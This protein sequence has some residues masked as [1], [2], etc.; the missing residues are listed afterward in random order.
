MGLIVYLPHR[1]REEGCE[2]DVHSRVQGTHTPGARCPA[3]CIHAIHDYTT[4]IPSSGSLLAVL[5][6]TL[7]PSLSGSYETAG[8]S[9]RHQRQRGRRQTPSPTQN[10]TML[11]LIR[12]VGKK[13]HHYSQPRWSASS[14]IRYRRSTSS[15]TRPRRSTSSHTRPRWSN[16]SHTRYRRSTSSHTRPRRST[17]SHTRP[18]W[19]NSSHTRYRR[20]TSSHTRYRWSNSS[21]TRYRQ[22]TSSHTR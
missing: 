1:R 9:K 3:D 18:R 12:S 17:S 16:S 5:G 7:V 22:S 6:S 4:H 10:Q 15:H 19:S 21:H 13:V 11:Q 8:S 2:Q 20:S 14:H